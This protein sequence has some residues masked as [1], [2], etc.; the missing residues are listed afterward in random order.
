MPRLKNL[1]K[2]VVNGFKFHEPSTG[3]DFNEWSFEAILS[4][5]IADRV[6]NPR[7]NLTTDR[8]AVSLEIQ[9]RNALDMIKIG[10]ASEYVIQE[11]EQPPKHQPL[12]VNRL[13]GV[14]AGGASL[15]DWIANKAEAVPQELAIQRAVTC[16]ACPLNDT[17]GDLL[18]YFTRP[19]SEAIRHAISSLGEMRLETPLDE[20]LGQCSACACPLRLKIHLPLERI[21]KGILPEQKAGLHPSCW[22]TREEQQK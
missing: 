9:N 1:H 8:D 19:V 10:M 15:I 14:V 6:A 17:K 4:K 16:V 20:K 21:L 3:R 5:V 13:A 22:I 7:F 18:S 12:S 2:P 11:G